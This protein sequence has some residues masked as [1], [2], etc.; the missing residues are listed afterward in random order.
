[1]LIDT[2][3]HSEVEE[4]MVFFTTITYHQ[5]TTILEDTIPQSILRFTITVTDTTS[6]MANMDTTKAHQIQEQ[7]SELF[8]MVEEAL[9]DLLVE[10]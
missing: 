10:F 6:T 7:E 9:E 8:D 2:L 1:M 5:T 3:V 4:P